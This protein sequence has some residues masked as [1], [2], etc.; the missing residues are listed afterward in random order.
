MLSAEF[1]LPI[2]ASE[3][4][5]THAFDREATGTGEVLQL[6]FYCCCYL[7]DQIKNYEI[8]WGGGLVRMGGYGTCVRGLYGET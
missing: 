8:G 6:N 7:H 3:R 2:P 5:Q 1:E 4:S